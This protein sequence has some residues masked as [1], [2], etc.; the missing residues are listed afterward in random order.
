MK[1][2]NEIDFNLLIQAG[3]VLQAP[4][5][6]VPRFIMSAF[7]GGQTGSE[8]NFVP[9]TPPDD[10]QATEMSLSVQYWY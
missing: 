8:L 6:S 3:E 7:C 9:Q 10:G 2:N 4:R 5:S 1:Y